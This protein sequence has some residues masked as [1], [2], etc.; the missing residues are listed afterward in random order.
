MAVLLENGRSTRA[1]RREAPSFTDVACFVIGFG[2]LGGYLDL[3]GMLLRSRFWD[4]N[5][6]FWEGRDFPWTVP[7]A[8]VLILSFAA[9]LVVAVNG[10][11]SVRVSTHA[12]AWLFA[13]LGI[14][15]AL[16][17]LPLSGFSS[18]LLAG[19]LG[20]LLSHAVTT[21]TGH[22]RHPRLALGVL[23]S[24]LALLAAASS[25]RQ[26]LRESRLVSHL[27]A[28]PTNARNV[29]LIVWDTVRAHNLSAYGYPRD[30]TPNL[31]KWAERGVRYHWALAPAPWT[32]PSHSSFFTGH[33]PYELNTQWKHKLDASQQTLAEFL[34]AK[35]YQ[36]AG[37]AA[38]TNYC[39]YETGLDRGF[40]HYEDYA[41]T[42]ASLLG[43]TAPGRWILRNIVNAGNFHG[44]KWV[45]FASRD[46][47]GINRSFL[48]WLE[49]RR[50]DRPFFA[51]L[52]YLDAHEPYVPPEGF[53]G[54]FGIPPKSARD[55]LFLT[56]YWQLDKERVAPRD[57][58][59]ARDCYD[60]CIAYLD[61]ELGRLL[62]TLERDGLLKDTLVIVTSDHGEE[63]GDHRVFGHASSLFMEEIHVPLVVLSPRTP[64]GRVVQEPVSLR[65]LPATVVD[66][67]GLGGGSPFPG[68]SL[69]AWWR[70][71]ESERPHPTTLAL[72]EIVN[73][74]AFH[75][76]P[77][78][79]LS[80]K[81]FQMS[82]VADGRHY[83]RD[84]S[85]AEQL[86]D[87]FRDPG[88]ELNLRDTTDGDLR[89]RPYRR[90]LFDV[91]SRNLGS[92]EVESAYLDPYRRWLKSLVEGNSFASTR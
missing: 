52:N 43:R 3:L 81:G 23:T 50:A 74:T 10:R 51:F 41:L 90:L 29:L 25:G 31:R 7:V 65:D 22:L 87:L 79:G 9:V 44:Q 6:Y 32:Y 12:A 54:R 48:Q 11:R 4:Q 13:T 38:N 70:P 69:A 2:L 59:M 47:N 15:G 28:A 53:V 86:Y 71:V 19:G 82:L 18:L 24:V 88:E 34:S 64:P 85:G 36:T 40:V 46:A 75:P 77:G 73:A 84:G 58:L 60:S 1:A 16:L 72:S 27:P 83:V 21:P 56:H 20:G 35:G 62:N 61:E 89:V 14:W 80:R 33:W 76:Q 57:V 68:Q 17:R 8:H 63:F 45:R 67:L 92:P 5:R 26:M 42:P 66:Q 30:T 39:S 91:L 37:F 49:Q 78:P 55:L